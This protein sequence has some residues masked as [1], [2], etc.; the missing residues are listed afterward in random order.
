MLLVLIFIILVQYAYCQEYFDWT[1]RLDRNGKPAGIYETTPFPVDSNTTSYS[2]T[3]DE[4]AVTYYL[5][6]KYF[7]D[8]DSGDDTND[9]LSFSKPK[10]TIGS[11]LSAAGNGNKTIIV[12][13][14]HGSFDGVYTENLN[15]NGHEG[16]DDTHRFMIV[17]YLQE[18]PIVDGNNGLTI[19]VR[20]NVTGSE[21]VA[22]INLQRLKIQNNAERGLMIKNHFYFNVFDVELY[23]CSNDPDAVGTAAYD[24]NTYI[25]NADGTIFSHCTSHHTYGHGYKFGDDCD[26][27]ILE[28]SIAY[29]CGWWDG[30]PESEFYGNHSSGLDFPNDADEKGES[31]ILRYNITYTTNFYGIQ[32][33]RQEAFSCHHNEVYN[34]I[35]F[36]SVIGSDAH[37]IGR[38]QVILYADSTCGKFYSNVIRD[39][40]S[41]N[42]D[43]IY[44]SACTDPNYNIDIYNNL[45]YGHEDECI[46][47]SNNTGAAINIFN[48]SLYGSNDDAI[49][50]ENM[51]DVTTVYNNI[52]YQDGSGKCAEY[53]SG[54]VNDY[55]L[56]YY[57]NGLIGDNIDGIHNVNP[58]TQ[59]FWVSIP[60]GVYNSQSAA[61]LA[62]SSA[63]DSATDLTALFTTSFNG[64]TRPR[65]AAWDLGAYEYDASFVEEISDPVMNIRV[66]TSPNGVVFEGLPYDFEIKIFNVAGEKV[67]E[68]VKNI[69]G[70]HWEW[71]YRN[72]EGKKVS[73]GVYLY[74]IKDIS[75]EKSSKGKFLIV[76]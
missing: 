4:G 32:L 7:V 71:N 14:S 44:I 38:H 21:D 16:V 11:A 33:R 36:D 57:P 45:I 15:L 54:T 9:G 22:Y 62:G 6:T 35:C 68:S 46:E 31:N 73:G 65:G 39:P 13:G 56:Y 61:L 49:L 18:R 23:N 10:I 75:E 43:G 72:R 48:N 59:N 34:T 53:L 40:F 41:S 29:E 20:C 1:V 2:I 8:G 74:S 30:F 52:L 26:N 12:R 60:G 51:G 42:T 67:F 37:S 3:F 58:T 55:N 47:V 25:W 27:I 70:K 19:V 63:I 5:G 76:K 50:D 28:W 66:Y 17:G 64:V 24:G 69:S